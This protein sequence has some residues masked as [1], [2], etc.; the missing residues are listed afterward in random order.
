MVTD[1]PIT[2]I[3]RSLSFP[4]ISGPL[5]SSD[6]CAPQWIPNSPIR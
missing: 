2:D 5:P 4:M 3:P 1:S 6:E